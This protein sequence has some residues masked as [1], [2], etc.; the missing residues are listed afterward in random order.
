[1]NDNLPAILV[2]A[3]GILASK[4]ILNKL[5][6]PTADYFGLGTRNLVQKSVENLNRIFWAAFEKVKVDADKEYQVNAR[7]LKAVWDEG[8][9]VEDVIA[10]EYFAGILASARTDDGQDDS[11]LPFSSVLHS[12]SSLELRLHYILYSLVA[13]G[14]Y[15]ADKLTS[16][17]WDGLEFSVDSDELLAAMDLNTADGPGSLLMAT[18][19]LVQHNLVRNEFAADVGGVREANGTQL[20][21]NRIVL[22]PNPYGASLFLRAL[23]LKGIHP[24][25]I[26]SIDLEYSVT[27]GVRSSVR[28]PRQVSYSHRRKKDPVGSLLD[29]MEDR[30]YEF[31]S[32]LEDV[33]EEL[34]KKAD[35]GPG[36]P[37]D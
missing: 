18:R 26:T 19:S 16:A 20:I 10:T 13:T 9:F 3:G 23:G 12:M 6:G 5:L 2:G 36:D 37:S 24:E 27:M 17:F 4:D 7:V 8:R 11:A 28:L 25:V 32:A 33:K 22:L 35:A 29:E 30:L 34:D 1:M 21:R 15:S 14:S 31:E